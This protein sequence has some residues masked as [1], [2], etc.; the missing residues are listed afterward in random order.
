MAENRVVIYSN[1]IADFQRCYEIRADQSQRI[2]IPVR[3]DHL[4]DVLASFNVYGNVKLQ[5]PPTFRPSNELEG[6]LSINPEQVLEDLATNLSGSHVRIE[7]ASGAIEGTLVGLHDEVEATAG[8][9]I[10]PKSVIVLADGG[11]R[12]CLLR[13]IQSFKFLDEDVQTEIDKA[14]QRNYQRIKPNSTF[15]ELVLGATGEDSEAVVQYTLPAAA[16]KISYRLRMVDSQATELQGFAI[17]DNNTDEDWTDFHVCVVTGE[18]ITFSTDL[19]ESKSPARMHVDLVSETALGAVE[20]EDAMMVMAAPPEADFAASYEPA[21]HGNSKSAR[22]S[23]SAAQRA[24]AETAAAEVHEVGDFSMFESA[25]VVTIP[26]KRSS[27]I[28]VFNVDVA[29]TKSVIHYKFGNHPN[30][31]Y[32]SVEFTNQ[33]GFSLGRGVC[34]VFEEAAYAGSCIIP[35]L[36]PDETRLLPHALETG[37]SIQRDQKR[38]RNKVVA[39]RL[40]EG[41]CYTSMRL[42]CETH[43]HV[44]NSRDAPY[45]LVLDH[46]YVLT[47]SDVEARRIS[48]GTDD[49]L[50]VSAKLADGVRYVI[51]IEPKSDFIVSI[52]EQA[53]EQ[54]RVE[55]V[56]KQ[57]ENFRIDWIIQNLVQTNG[58]LA[59]DAGVR[60][61]LGIHD[62]LETKRQD[63]ADAVEETERLESRQERLRQNINTGGQDELTSRWRSDL[64]QAEQAICKIEEEELPALRAEEKSLRLTLMNAL[65][66]LAVEWAADATSATDKTNL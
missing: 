29:G 35:A 49:A 30:R 65:K 1:G 37:V 18:P 19:A 17:V 6:N 10:H 31:P 15:V 55:L 14:L 7:R 46:D 54:S 33:T 40:A 24:T 34:T 47:E 58:P 42:W 48:G 32:R 63:V 26:A 27:V 22:R 64:D 8:K 52:M 4:G 59:L 60:Q 53:I 41:F 43:Y 38:R 25:S 36:K 3:Q 13:E 5:S 61:C 51:R 28:P 2:S 66:S 16:W 56:N 45:E 44:R 23:F 62:E 11:L 57:H 12:R 39:L 9:P 50:D 20:V 21:F